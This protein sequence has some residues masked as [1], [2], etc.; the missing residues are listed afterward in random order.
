MLKNLLMLSLLVSTQADASRP[1]SATDGSLWDFI[2]A[3]TPPGDSDSHDAAMSILAT[4]ELQQARVTESAYIDRAFKLAQPPV[5]FYKDPVAYLAAD[6]LHL[7]EIDPSEFDIPVVVNADVIRWMKYFTGNGRKW[8]GKWLS[9]GGKYQPM[10]IEKLEAAGLPRDMVYLSMIE[11]GYATHAYSHAAAA[12]LWQFIASTGKAYDLRVDWWV[13]ERRNPELATDAAIEYLAHLY[14]RY[15]HWYLA[16]AAYNAGPTRVSRGIKNHGTKDFWVLKKKGSFRPETDNYVPK[17][18]AAA[19]IGKHPERYGF[20][21]IV[22]Q[23]PMKH[24]TVTVSAN[25]GID[26]LARCAGISVDEFRTLNPQLRRWAL[27]PSP[28]RQTVHVPHKGSKKFL[29][30]LDKV[31]QGQRITHRRH[32]VKKGETLGTIGT[33]YGVK[34]NTIQVANK[35]KNPNR[36]SVGQNL[37]IPMAGQ[38]IKPTALASSTGGKPKKPSKPKTKYH[39]VR[40][41]QTLSHVANKYKVRVSDLMRW[42]NIKSANKIRVGQKLKLYGTGKPQIKW[43]SYTVRRGDTLS[44]IARRHGCSTNDLKKWNK[45]S[46]TRIMAGQKLKVQRK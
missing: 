37:V 27:P 12:G 32:T 11:S 33:K 6:P 28:A 43:T 1:S 29:A 41:G 44:T 17:L 34:A 7:K 21:D 13:D 14:K 16:W 4:K 3:P 39:T 18:L 40:S 22:R 20:G 36:I 9:R 19:I 31:P 23:E 10:M 35:I 15:D 26:V 24:E 46:S 42:N 25:V 5:D 45:L 38:P 2:E 8:Y 30:A